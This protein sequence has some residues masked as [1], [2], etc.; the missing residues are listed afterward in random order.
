VLLDPE[1]EGGRS[2]LLADLWEIWDEAKTRA[3]E[4]IG[5]VEHLPDLLAKWLPSDH[6]PTTCSMR[7]SRT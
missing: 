6:D 1:L 3:V 4:V 7:A 2:H 5:A